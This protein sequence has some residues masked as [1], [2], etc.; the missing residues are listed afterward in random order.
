MLEN[1]N[2]LGPVACTVLACGYVVVLI[3][4]TVSNYTKKD[5][6]TSDGELSKFK[7]RF[8]KAHSLLITIHAM[9]GVETKY[10]KSHNL[11]E[12]HN[13]LQKY[14]DSFQEGKEK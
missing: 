12:M 10:S 7:T 1:A 8:N 5:L 11:R 2:E 13:L 4:K 9:I 3:F 6:D 14:V